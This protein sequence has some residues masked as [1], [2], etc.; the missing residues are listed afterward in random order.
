MAPRAYQH[1]LMPAFLLFALSGCGGG[2]TTQAP[3]NSVPQAFTRQSASLQLAPATAKQY[4]F[5]GTGGN[6]V[7]VDTASIGTPVSTITNGIVAPVLFAM[8]GSND[9][10]VA[11]SNLKITEYKS[12]Y[13]GAPIASMT[14]T[15]SDPPLTMS[16]DSTG[17]LA[18]AGTGN[19][20]FDIFEPPYTAPAI[21]LTIPAGGVT[22]V[23]VDSNRNVLVGANGGRLKG[24]VYEYAPPY[25]SAPTEPIKGLPQPPS[26][27]RLDSNGH[28]WIAGVHFLYEYASSYTGS[29]LVTYTESS[30][31]T[32]LMAPVGMTVFGT[33]NIVGVLN[34]EFTVR[35]YIWRSPYTTPSGIDKGTDLVANG[36]GVEGTASGVLWAVASPSGGDPE[37]LLRWTGTF[38]TVPTAFDSGQPTRNAFE[39]NPLLVSPPMI[40]P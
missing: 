10:F 24:R 14:F 32:H 2:M 6:T 30:S 31:G 19:G 11:N 29:P 17:V 21:V 22:S 5:V 36:E 26:Q 7:Y 4:L 16:V 40:L 3:V 20:Q 38:H 18:V 34:D 25:T 1:V 23:V 13:T 37:E 39:G 28:L 35:E 8:D 12:P 9:L 33:S 27:M 15:G